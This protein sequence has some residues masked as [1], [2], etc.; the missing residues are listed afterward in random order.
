MIFFDD[1]GAGSAGFSHDHDFR[2]RHLKAL[3]PLVLQVLKIVR[4]GGRSNSA[5]L[6]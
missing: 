3:G 5:C 1:C 2:K 4:D 6:A